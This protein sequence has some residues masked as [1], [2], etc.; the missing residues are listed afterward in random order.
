[1][2]NLTIKRNK[3]FVACLGK[4]KVYIEDPNANELTINFVPCR[5]L[6]ELKNGEEKTF[7][8]GENAAKIFVIADTLSKDYCNEYYDIPEGSE[9]ISL[10]GQNKFN[11]ANGNAF[12]FDNNNDENVTEYH[13]QGT[14][15]GFIVLC[16]SIVIG[17][18]LGFTISY[19]I[20]R[21]K[22]PADKS[23]SSG[24]ISITL[25]ESFKV[26]EDETY[27]AKFRS[28]DIAVFAVK[29]SKSALTNYS[30]SDYGNAL[31]TWYQLSS[32]LQTKDELIYFKHDYTDPETNKTF[33]YTTFVFETEDTFWTVEFA[34][35]AKN[36]EKYADE[37]FDWAKSISFS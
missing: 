11:P 17:L 26:E 27:S 4:M 23:F 5:K 9:D 10:S 20:F 33:T 7:E 14:K 28:S 13:K 32:E 2:R 16:A 22:E 18:I 15:K 35:N 1:M 6:G 12:R 34:S 24:G 21:E 8:I 36:A 37:I 31:I 19:F 29:E 25:D 30:L 3:S